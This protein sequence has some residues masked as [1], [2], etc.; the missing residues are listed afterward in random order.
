MG[1]VG[2]G[3]TKVLMVELGLRKWVGVHPEAVEAEGGVGR[4]GRAREP[5]VAINEGKK[6]FTIEAA[7]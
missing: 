1:V 5:G 6:Q 4:T 2:Q 3:S 7:E